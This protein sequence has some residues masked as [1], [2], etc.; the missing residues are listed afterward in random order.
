MS[1]TARRIAFE[2]D[3]HRFDGVEERSVPSA[4]NSEPKV[5]WVV[6]MDGQ[7]A[8]EFHGAFPYRDED[9]RARIIEWYDIQR[10]R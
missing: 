7:P 3:G 4:A 6:H 2:H 1:D 9:V 8:L 10:P 5:R